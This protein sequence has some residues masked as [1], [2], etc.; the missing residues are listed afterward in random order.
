MKYTEQE[1]RI[2]LAYFQQFIEERIFPTGYKSDELFHD[3]TINEIV[4]RGNTRN[5]VKFKD[6]LID[7]CKNMPSDFCPPDIIKIIDACFVYVR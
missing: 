2:V 5:H 4:I 1:A 6:S 7:D 3:F